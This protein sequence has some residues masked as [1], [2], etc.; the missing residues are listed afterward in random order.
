MYDSIGISI[1]TEMTRE[2]AAVRTANIKWV[3]AGWSQ[4]NVVQRDHILRGMQRFMRTLKAILESPRL[5]PVRTME[6]DMARVSQLTD[7]EIRNGP[8]TPRWP[9]A[10]NAP[11]AGAARA[12]RISGMSGL[13]PNDSRGNGINADLETFK[14][15][16]GKTTE[17]EMCRCCLLANPVPVRL[18]PERDEL[19]HQL[20]Y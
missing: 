5:P 14:A 9:A 2:A 11:R 12:F 7:A 13:E 18:R 19:T 1:Y 17:E 15:H 16:L 10:A 4:L 6:E 3:R 8:A 20:E